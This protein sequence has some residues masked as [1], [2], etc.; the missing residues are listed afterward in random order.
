MGEVLQNWP[1]AFANK[2]ANLALTKILL[3]PKT[4]AFKALLLKIATLV[5]R[6]S[7]L[8]CPFLLSGVHLNFVHA[9][10]VSAFCL[11]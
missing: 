6:V 10:V 1:I 7:G 2:V 4:M 5:K 9:V 11:F 8:F 3:P